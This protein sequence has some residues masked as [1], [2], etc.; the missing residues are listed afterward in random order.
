MSYQLTQTGAEIQ[1]I[2]DNAASYQTYSTSIPA[3]GWIE[4]SAGWYTNTI[5]VTGILATDT[6]VVDVNLT[7]ASSQT[8]VDSILEN[9]A[10]VFRITCSAGSITCYASSDTSTDIPITLGVTR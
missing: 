7:S 9:W 4:Q 8:D 6:P 5:N 1:A 10:Y 3:N 2:L